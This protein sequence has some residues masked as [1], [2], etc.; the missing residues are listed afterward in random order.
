M[1]LFKVIHCVKSV[2]IRRYS[3]LNFPALGLN[4][5]RYGVPLFIQSECGKI[6]TRITSN[7]DTFYAVNKDTKTIF[8]NVFLVYLWL[9]FNRYLPWDQQHFINLFKIF[10]YKFLLF[11]RIL[12]DLGIG[13]QWFSVCCVHWSHWNSAST[14]LILPV[15]FPDAHHIGTW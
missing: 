3:G 2:H 1:Y 10:F 7:T 13:W 14:N 4:M 6:W 12:V 11:P 9:I 5:E 15:I 8:L